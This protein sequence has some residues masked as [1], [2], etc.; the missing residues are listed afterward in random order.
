MKVRVR[1]L[2]VKGIHVSFPISTSLS[3]SSCSSFT[4]SAS[5][6]PEAGAAKSAG[7]PTQL[8]DYFAFSHLLFAFQQHMKA[9]GKD[10][11]LFLLVLP[12]WPLIQ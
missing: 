7:A 8:M 3:S 4:F 2:A 5:S 6:V 11:G 1:H 10:E 12:A 9:S